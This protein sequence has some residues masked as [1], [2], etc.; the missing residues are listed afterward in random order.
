LQSTTPNR[1]HGQ[2][3]IWLGVLFQIVLLTILLLQPFSAGRPDGKLQ[4]D[5]LDVGQGDAALVTMPNGSTLLVDGGGRPSFVSASAIAS[6]E[7]SAGLFERES[8]SIGE[9]V[10]SEYLWWRGLDSVDYVLA[11]HADA[12]HIDG[13][14]DVVRNF[15]VRCALVGRTPANDPEYLRFLQTLETTKT[16][17]EIIQAGDQLHFGE[18]T[19]TVLWPGVSSESNAPSGN[20]DS[21]VIRLQFGERSILLTG[22]IEKETEAQILSSNKDLHVDVVKVPHHGSRT[23]STEPFVAATSPRVAVVSVGQT[24]MFGHPHKDVVDR[25]VRSGAEVLTTG[26]SG[27]ISVSTD[28]KEMWVKKFVE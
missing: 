6:G 5:F 18:V 10:T 19:A 24:S 23:S 7:S 20:N 8:R 22:D 13:L 14:N 27:T 16:H 15:S 1:R 12:D 4:V 11:T 2:R 21:V 25:W 26:R 17:V 28:G 9:I 3:L